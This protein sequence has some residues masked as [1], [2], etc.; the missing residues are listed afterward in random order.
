MV[1]VTLNHLIKAKE[2]YKD[3]AKEIDAWYKVAKTARWRNFVEVGQT[4]KDADNVDG[5]VIFNIRQNRYRLVT[6]IHHSREKDGRLTEGHIYIR[7]F[8]THEEYDTPSNW[9]KEFKRR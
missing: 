2:K 1:V 9:D 8:L 7:S 3:A 5:Y 4:F 6:V